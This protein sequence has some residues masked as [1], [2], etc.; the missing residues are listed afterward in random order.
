MTFETDR[1]PAISAV[2]SIVAEA[3][4]DF[5]LA[6]L[7]R[8]DLLAGL[9][10][11]KRAFCLT[12]QEYPYIAPTW[13]WASLPTETEYKRSRTRHWRDAD[14]EASV[15]NAWTAL[16]CPNLYGP[17]S[18]GAIVLSGIHCDVEITISERD[19]LNVQVDFGHGEVEKLFKGYFHDEVLDLVQVESDTNVDRRGGNSRYLRRATVPQ[20]D[21]RQPNCSGTAHLLWLEKDI[22]L[23]LM[24]SH[25][26]EGAYERLGIFHQKRAIKM[27]RMM[28]RSSITLV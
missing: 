6:G 19:S 8:D 3:A 28:Q 1:L 9:C 2:A 20:P 12:F 23:I 13:S 7:R 14:L 26:K 15:L 24:P 22:S 17:V 4:G 21:R 11:S 25:R 16:G 10:W 5:Y 18:D 27:P